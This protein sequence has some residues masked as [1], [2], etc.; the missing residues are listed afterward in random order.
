PTRGR[1]LGRRGRSADDGAQGGGGSHAHARHPVIGRCRLTHA[2]RARPDDR[3]PA[4]P[5]PDEARSVH[6]GPASDPGGRA[7]GWRADPA[8]GRE[9]ARVARGPRRRSRRRGS[10]GRGTGAHAITPSLTSQ[11]VIANSGLSIPAGTPAVSRC[12]L[13]VL[14]LASLLLFSA[15]SER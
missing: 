7:R 2:R 5:S 6:E 9:R 11:N 12:E 10:V 3:G 13:L 4:V 15:N 8:A 14:L 1:T